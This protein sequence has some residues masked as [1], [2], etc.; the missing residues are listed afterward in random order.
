[1][2]K[3]KLYHTCI[4]MLLS[5]VTYSQSLD[6]KKSPFTGV[7][8]SENSPII[9]YNKKWYLLKTIDGFTQEE[10]IKLCKEN[11]GGKWKKRFSE[12]LVYVL[13]YGKKHVVKK[14]V[15][16]NLQ[17]KGKL[18]KVSAKLTKENRE[19][20]KLY[21]KK[22]NL[23]PQKISSKQALEDINEFERILKTKSSYIQLIN[24]NYSEKLDVLRSFLSQ[25]KETIDVNY[26]T[27]ELAKILAEI[28][29]R[30]ASVKND[31][32]NKKN[33]ATYGL[34]L[35]FGI[36][37]LNDKL[38]AVKEKNN[39]YELLHKKY[40]YI[41]SVNK[42]SI[43][44]YLENYA[45]KH[46]KAPKESKLKRAAESIQRIGKLYFENNINIED[47]ISVT[48]HDDQGNVKKENYK[49]SKKKQGY[50]SRTASNFRKNYNNLESNKYKK[51]DTL[52]GENI[53][54]IAIPRMK[55]LKRE[56]KYKEYLHNV[57]GNF[58]NTKALILDLRNN[59]GGRRDVLNLLG[60]YFIPKDKSPWVANIAYVRTDSVFEDYKSMDNRY[61]FRYGSKRFNEKDREAINSFNNNFIPYVKADESKFT[62]PYYMILKS[63]KEFYKGIVYILVDE[64]TFSAASVF[65][66]SL[67]GLPNVKIVGNTTDG[68]SGKSQKF[69]L[70][71]SQIR[72]KVSTM[73]S[74]QRNGKTLDG[75]GTQPDVF[76]PKSLEQLLKI[77]DIQLDFLVKIIS[78]KGRV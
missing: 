75:N 4:I 55:N 66:A 57:I 32:K 40:P 25:K 62:E 20:V 30:H 26:L 77:E 67:K 52:L 41:Q 50:K 1:M 64:K 47:T 5:I 18:F 10:L 29:D 70:T 60:E 71:N 2:S 31:L 9:R 16:L 23:P 35:P 78:K 61:L 24:F 48:F 11:F 13:F 8:W 68:S 72:V 3:L 58:S 53:G 63:R 15:E 45:Y 54:Y 34:R 65:A 17:D 46:K 44:S 37:V 7:K 51:L 43:E 6:F 19:F 49:L 69:Y 33:H 28:G 59:P 56:K 22:F 39:E 21:N 73:I 14:H 36:T 12:D 38:I 76:L 27:N 74:Y 42:V